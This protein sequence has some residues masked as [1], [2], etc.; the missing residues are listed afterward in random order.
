MPE[1]IANTSALQ[2]CSGR[3]IDDR[4]TKRF[5]LR[6]RREGRGQGEV[7]GMHRLKGP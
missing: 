7:R 4:R 3:R 1:V 5:P 2:Y 6:S